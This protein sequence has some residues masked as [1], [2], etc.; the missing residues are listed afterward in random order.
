MWSLRKVDK[1]ES[2]FWHSHTHTNTQAKMQCLTMCL[3]NFSFCVNFLALQ[4]F[5]TSFLHFTNCDRSLRVYAYSCTQLIKHNFQLIDILSVECLHFITSFDRCSLTRRWIS[6]RWMFPW[7]TSRM[8]YSKPTVLIR[9][10][11]ISSL[12]ARILNVSTPATTS[13]LAIRLW[14]SS[15][16]PDWMLRSCQR[17][18]KSILLGSILLFGS[19]EKVIFCIKIY[20]RK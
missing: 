11:A 14:S 18:S 9:R 17:S 4:F 3:R 10:R 6:R 15:V 13:F 12:K 19:H 1:E 5:L 8:S 2:S 16:C 20:A 7:R